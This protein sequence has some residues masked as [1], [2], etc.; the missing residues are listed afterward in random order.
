MFVIQYTNKRCSVLRLPEA[1]SEIF[2]GH[3]QE[4]VMLWTV[5]LILVFSV[6]LL[7]AIGGPFGTYSIGNLFSRLLYWLVLI[8]TSLVL[9]VLVKRV[10]S[11]LVPNLSV[12]WQECVVILCLTLIYTPLLRLWSDFIS[13]GS[14]SQMVPFWRQS[15]E[16]GAICIALALIYH[17][18]PIV[19][20]SRDIEPRTAEKIRPRLLDRIPEHSESEIL[21]LSVNGHK[22]EVVTNTGTVY[23]RMRFADAVQEMSEVTGFCTHRSHWVTAQAIVGHEIHNERPVLILCNGDVVPVSRKYQPDLEAAGFL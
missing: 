6:S 16:V 12:L 15:L 2:Q 10:V 4:Q 13:P 3:T 18:L 20:R 8:A 11:R 9:G 23:L 5:R 17:G 22:V 7:L 21:R 14:V 19:L 1:T